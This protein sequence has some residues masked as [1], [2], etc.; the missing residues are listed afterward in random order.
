MQRFLH[1]ITLLQ[2]PLAKNARRL[3]N[4]SIEGGVRMPKAKAR[5]AVIGG[6]NMDIGGFP[7][8]QLV[9]GD[10]NPGRVRM[11][12]G[13]VGRN[14]AEN[15]VHL[16]M[17]THLITALGNDTNGHAIMSDCRAK[18][19]HIDRSI[20]VNDMNTSVYLF[21]DDVNGDLNCAIN[22][23][24]IQL[25][26][27]PEALAPHLAFL[28]SMDAVVMDANLSKETIR[29]L[30]ERL[31]VPI[32]ADAVSAAKVYKLKDALAH[33]FCLKPNRIEAELLCNM[34][35]RDAIDG[36]EAAGRL[37]KMGVKRVFLTMGSLGAICADESG[38]QFIPAGNPKIVNTSGA[39]D[40]FTA[41]LIWGHFQKLSLKECGEAGMAAGTIAMET[42]SAV[43]PEMSPERLK[44][45]MQ[46]L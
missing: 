32:Y 17:E 44:K 7:S 20:I 9:M 25:S 34:Q 11:T 36:Y 15:L 2:M 13:G 28:N 22:D 33:V 35:I 14:I 8:A 10:S 29:F 41:A 16:G 27:T 6:A 37:L 43:N 42:V 18:G 4:R 12:L 3:Y 5:V 24:D 1:K 38:C 23:M 39:G 31:C 40:A 26:I 30:A 19:I 21:M 45:S 46:M